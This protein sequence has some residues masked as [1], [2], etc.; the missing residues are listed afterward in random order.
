V[1]IGIIDEYVYK[2]DGR[3][4]KDLPHLLWVGWKVRDHGGDVVHDLEALVLHI[5]RVR[6]G[7]VL[8]GR[9]VTYNPKNRYIG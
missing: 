7:L 5:D 3:E 8:C 9:R 6:A 2:E 4:K 1:L